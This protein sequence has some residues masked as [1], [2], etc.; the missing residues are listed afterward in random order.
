MIDRLIGEGLEPVSRALA[1]CGVHVSCWTSLRWIKR[2]VGGLRLEGVKVAG[3][4][5]TSTD[6]VKRFV[7][8]DQVECPT[9][10]EAKK[11]ERT[12]LATERYLDDLGLGRS[13]G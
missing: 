2:G 3:R 4:W 10:E 11:T 9:K 13:E 1:S 8:A 7:G 12:A 6:A 5:L